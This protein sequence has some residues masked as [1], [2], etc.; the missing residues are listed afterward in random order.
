MYLSIQFSLGKIIFINMQINP[1]IFR[2]YDIRGIYPT[3]LN[4]AAAYKIGQAFAFLVKEKSSASEPKIVVGRDMRIASPSLAQSLIDGLVE[5]G[6]L[7]DDIGLSTVDAVYFAV[8]KLGY[9]GGIMVTASH[10]PKEYG[11][12]K[13]VL[14][15]ME[16]V[17]G[18]DI[19]KVINRMPEKGE[20]SVGL[21]KERDLWEEY[22]NHV[23]SFV[24]LDK[25]S[26]MK[27]VVDAGNGM[28]GLA[29]P[30]IAERLPIEVL[31]IHFELDGN[32]PGRESN[33]LLPGATDQAAAV[34][35]REKAH[36][37]V[38][39]DGDTDRLIFVDENGQMIQADTTLILLAKHF[40]KRYPGKAVAYN[41]ICSKAVPEFIEKFGGRPV[42]TK[43]GFI[44]VSKGLVEH[45]GVLGGEVS[46][47]YSFA[48]N[49]YADSGMIAFVIILQL[50]SEIGKPLSEVVAEFNPYHR[51]DEVNLTVANSAMILDK[52]KE[53][54]RDAKIDE[55][56]GV[57][58]DHGHWWFNVRPSN[59]EPLLRITVEANNK[60]EMEK[61]REELVSYIKSLD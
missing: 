49:H 18:V 10:N 28:A 22:I 12:M 4:E 15:N 17:S 40:L 55:L 53:K 39:F 24:E 57:T 38:L 31:P 52:I 59:T 47:H 41:A 51:G 56:D 9:D 43:V 60:E 2:S 20:T 29:I 33:P 16:W 8:G 58:V 14:K 54:Y 42:R 50:L 25:I 61:N 44:N 46:A 11:G 3:E 37:G 36:L 27:V 13:I 30:K 26:P 6:L 1:Q 7:V 34:I 35:V 45:D 21:K 5:A 23:L 48:D 19:Q 32:F